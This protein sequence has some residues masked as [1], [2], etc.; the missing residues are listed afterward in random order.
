M[1]IDQKWGVLKSTTAWYDRHR[2]L[3]CRGRHAVLQH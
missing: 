3:T 1:E 2:K